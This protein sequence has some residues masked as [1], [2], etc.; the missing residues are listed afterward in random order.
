VLTTSIILQTIDRGEADELVVFLS[1]DLGR[2]AGIAKNA[3][4]SRIRFSGHLEPLSLVEL[5]VR[6]RRK[7]DLVWIDESHVLDGRLNLRKSIHK[8][9]WARYF[10]ELISLFVPEAHPDAPLFEF[11]DNLLKEMDDSDLT[12]VQL[13]IEEVRLL[14]LL[15]YAPR[16][17]A[18]PACGKKIEPGEYAYFSVQAGGACHA[19]CV[20]ANDEKSVQLSPGAVAVARRGPVLER[21][22]AA[23]LKLHDQ[24][25]KELRSALSNFVRY[26]RGGQINSLL[27]M[28]KMQLP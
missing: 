12:P 3:K 2:S 1:K 4:R 23:R 20:G 19:K 21:K 8:I 6:M 13:M 17:D 9:A 16:F 27:F 11:F 28:E 10:G 24:G 5:L 7:D 15:G 26:L 22:A 14:G 25:L 18:C